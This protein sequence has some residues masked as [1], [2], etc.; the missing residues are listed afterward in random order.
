MAASGGNGES[1]TKP[2]VYSTPINFCPSCGGQVSKQVPEGEVEERAVCTQCHKVH[3]VNPKMVVGCVASYDNKVLLCKRA[4]K[5]SLGL[6]T[7][8]AG[9]MELGES[10]AEGAARET[11]EEALTIVHIVAPYAHL[12]IPLIG[13]SY[14]IFRG[15]LEKADFKPGPESL[16]VRLF[17]LDEI[18]WDLL[19]FTSV[20]VVL[21]KYI[22][23]IERGAFGVHHGVI[24]KKPGSSPSDPDGYVLRDHMVVPGPR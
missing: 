18:P 7:L 9:F 6:W 19:A 15:E 14:I 20:T 21:K 3:Y 8:P 22:E 2:K 16:D 4:I 17:A 13:Q 10:A 24:E 1:T 12:D 23:D 11:Q 5:P